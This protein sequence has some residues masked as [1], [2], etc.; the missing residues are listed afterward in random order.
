VISVIVPLYNEANGVQR[1]SDC[2]A[3][4]LASLDDCWEIILVNDGSRDTTL[5]ECRAMHERDRRFKVLSFTR[6]FG[7]QQAVTAGL[8]FATGDWVAII[9]GDMQ[10]PPEFLAPMIKQCRTGYDVVYAIRA[11]R[12]EGVVKRVCYWTFYRILVRLSTVDIPADV[13]DFCV[14][15]R[16]AVEALNSLP[17]TERF[18]RGLR[19]WIGFKQCGMTYERNSRQYGESKYSWKAL[20]KLATD[21]ILGF[22]TKPLRIFTY[23]GMAVAGWSFLLG[24]IFLY[25]YCVNVT[26]LGYNPRDARGWTSLILTI[27]FLGGLQLIGL[28]VVGE[29]VGRVYQEVRNRPGYLIESTVGFED[30]LAQAA[31]ES[32]ST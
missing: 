12:K 30:H 20:M 31:R 9:D 29:Y 25:Q 17:E 1:V 6:N 15:S 26:L 32:S 11:K 7:H 14:M 21:G 22:S 23:V 5:D 10:D 19:A 3:T 28:G 24:L 27:L 8:R 4:T 2:I 13:G 18:V 16:R